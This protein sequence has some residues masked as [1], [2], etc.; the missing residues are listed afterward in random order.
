MSTESTSRARLHQHLRTTTHP[1]HTALQ[2]LPA[3]VPRVP[4]CATTRRHLHHLASL[5]AGPVRR[6]AGGFLAVAA[7][8]WQA[9]RLH[10]CRLLHPPLAPRCILRPAPCTR[11]HP[12]PC[13]LVRLLADARCGLRHQGVT[14]GKGFQG[15]MKRWGFGGQ[16]ATHGTSLSHRS[17][18][19]AGGAAGNM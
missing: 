2:A 17:M 18:G 14:K 6:R 3:R 8:G 11:L 10:V 16:P 15:V 7:C 13:R 9:A 1:H 19:S 5:P 12:A 4:R